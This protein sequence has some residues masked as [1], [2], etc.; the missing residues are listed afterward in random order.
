MSVSLQKN[1]FSIYFI[2]MM[3]SLGKFSIII[4]IIIVTMIIFNIIHLVTVEWTLKCSKILF[5]VSIL[6]TLLIHSSFQA[7]PFNH[8]KYPNY[9]PNWLHSW[10]LRRLCP[11]Q[12]VYE[13]STSLYGNA[14][15]SNFE[16]DPL[17][18]TSVAKVSDRSTNIPPRN[19]I[20]RN[21]NNNLIGE[22]IKDIFS[23]SSNSQREVSYRLQTFFSDHKNELNHIH[24]VSLLHHSARARFVLHNAI[25]L[26]FMATILSRPS[27]RPTRAG[28][29]AQII[30]G[31][32][33]M[34]IDDDPPSPTSSSSEGGVKILLKVANAKLLECQ[35][36]FSGKDI[37]TSLYGLQKF[38][39]CEPEVVELLRNLAK[40]LKSSN[41]T[42]N[43]QEISNSLYGIVYLNLE[44]S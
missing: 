23:N 11:P 27:T 16:K 14:V 22:K 1:L 15:S 4:T 21:Q 2:T 41:A 20:Y 13:L 28:E 17:I 36:N 19:R 29:V 24:A 6:L 38:T 31:L 44:I 40:K 43:G 7:F 35:D 33:L 32:R 26:H 3:Y 9:K 42:L 18:K 37:A 25:P 12:Y 30:Y 34:S 8:G 5:S 39:G 10:S